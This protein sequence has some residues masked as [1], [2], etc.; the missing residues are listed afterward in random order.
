MEHKQL[1]RQAKLNE[2]LGCLAQKMLMIHHKN[3]LSEFVLHDLCQEDCFNLQKAAYLVNNPDFHC[4]KGVAGFCKTDGAKNYDVW[5]SPED[6]TKDM[7]NS[8]FNQD[9]KQ[10]YQQNA[11]GFAQSEIEEIAGKLDLKNPI[12]CTWVMKHNNKGILIFECPV[13]DDISVHENI[14]KGASFLSFCPIHA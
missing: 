1:L 10:I 2:C 3:N 13:S 5:L 14:I 4:T 7:E 9:V 11:N 8:K 12:F 6:F